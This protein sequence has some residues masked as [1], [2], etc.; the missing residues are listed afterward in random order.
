MFPALQCE[1]EKSPAS[2]PGYVALIVL[3][4]DMEAYRMTISAGLSLEH[5]TAVVLE[6]KFE[7]EVSECGP[8]QDKGLARIAWAD[9]AR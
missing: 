5:V 9:C 1:M 7:S 8:V 2:R 3:N 6:R 4:I